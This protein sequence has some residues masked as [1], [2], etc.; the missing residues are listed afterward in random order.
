MNAQFDRVLSALAD[1]LP[2]VAERLETAR[3]DVLACTAF[4]KE[5]WRP[6]WSKWRPQV[7]APSDA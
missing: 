5:V 6:I 3:V 7:Y 1:K 2:K 4:P